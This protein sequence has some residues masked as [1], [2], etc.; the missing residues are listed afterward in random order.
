MASRGF[1]ISGDAHIKA[2]QVGDE[3][4][5]VAM[6]RKL[7][8]NGLFVLPARYPTVPAGQGDPEG[9]PDRAA[10][11]ERRGSAGKQT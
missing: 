2:V 9:Q 8:R 11:S 10:P 7:Y 6:A 5:A 4:L 1:T 3:Q